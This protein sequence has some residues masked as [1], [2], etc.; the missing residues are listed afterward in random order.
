ML[1]KSGRGEGKKEFGKVTMVRGGITSKV[2]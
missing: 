2:E 1:W